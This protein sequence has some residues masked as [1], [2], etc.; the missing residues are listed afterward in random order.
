MKYLGILTPT[1]LVTSAHAGFVGI[2]VQD[3]TDNGVGLAEYAIYAKFDNPDDEL[4]GIVDPMVT[5]TTSFYHST[6]DGQKSALP[7]TTAENAIADT[8]DVDSFV[9]IGLATGDGNSTIVFQPFDMDAFLNG[10]SLVGTPGGGWVQTNV[11]NPQGTPNAEGLVLVAVLSPTNDVTG[12][13]GI[14]SGNL[15]FG[16]SDGRSG[17]GVTYITASFTTVPAPSAGLALF[18]ATALSR[19]R[20]RR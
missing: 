2:V 9:T 17:P 1:L 11:G 6:V 12:T 18:A 20:R 10:S 4:I 16:F 7:W 8:P 13:P 5:V 3:V 19:S 14:I 15:T